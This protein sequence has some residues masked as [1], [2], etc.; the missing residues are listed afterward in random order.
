MSEEITEAEDRSAR[1]P[2]NLPECPNMPDAL[3]KGEDPELWFSVDGIGLGPANAKRA[4]LAV[5]ICEECPH[6][7]E[8]GNYAVENHVEYGVWGGLTEADRETIWAQ[9]LEE[10]S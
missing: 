4:L 5:A 2:D 10:A 6:V 1:I 7:T 3:C 8:C 9:E